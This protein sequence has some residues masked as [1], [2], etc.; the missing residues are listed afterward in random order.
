M[1]YAL[2]YCALM[3]K[4][5]ACIKNNA[6]RFVAFCAKFVGLYLDNVSIVLPLEYL[7]MFTAQERKRL[8]LVFSRLCFCL[9]T[10]FIQTSLFVSLKSIRISVYYA[11]RGYMLIK[12]ITKTFL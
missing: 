8:I 6:H 10:I 9:E 5:F 2:E 1:M 3:C 4:F 12:T 7:N 11:H